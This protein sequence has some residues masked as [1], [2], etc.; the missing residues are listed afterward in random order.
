MIWSIGEDSIDCIDQ[1]NRLGEALVSF[2]VFDLLHMLLPLL[3]ESVRVS[4]FKSAKLLTDSI[5]QKPSY[6]YF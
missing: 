1:V 6:F 3:D 5:L 4:M 2:G